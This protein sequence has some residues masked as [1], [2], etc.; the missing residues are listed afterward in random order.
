VRVVIESELDLLNYPSSSLA[1]P[2]LHV[3]GPHHPRVLPPPALL[4]EGCRPRIPSDVR[5][6]E[7]FGRA[8]KDPSSSLAHPKLNALPPGSHISYT[9]FNFFLH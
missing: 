4:L 9:K 5:G 6:N 3:R 8:R 1:H 7:R 2:N